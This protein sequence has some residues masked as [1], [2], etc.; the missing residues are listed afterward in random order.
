ML[1]GNKGYKVLIKSSY[2]SATEL[3]QTSN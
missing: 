2:Q 3:V 1:A